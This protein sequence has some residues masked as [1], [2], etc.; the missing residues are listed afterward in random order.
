MM[1]LAIG[2]QQ[3]HTVPMGQGPFFLG[4]ECGFVRFSKNFIF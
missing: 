4:N 1:P 2:A 3:W